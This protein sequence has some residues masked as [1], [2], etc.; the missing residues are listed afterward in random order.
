MSLETRQFVVWAV[1]AIVAAGVSVLTAAGVFTL[2]V[3]WPIAWNMLCNTL[4]GVDEPMPT[5]SVS[6]VVVGGILASLVL[7]AG[8]RL[9]ALR[10][11]RSLF[12]DYLAESIAERARIRDMYAE[13]SLRDR[14]ALYD[15]MSP[16]RR[17]NLMRELTPEAQRELAGLHESLP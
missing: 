7:M 5:R 14:R 11:Y 9:V 4:L 16:E 8:S 13:L 6:A 12:Q 1:T 3:C 17:R 10:V 2:T 15:S